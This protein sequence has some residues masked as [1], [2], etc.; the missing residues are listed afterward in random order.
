MDTEQLRSPHEPAEEPR[1]EANR[2]AGEQFDS[3]GAMSARTPV[4]LESEV[5]E[6]RSQLVSVPAGP[7]EPKRAPHAELVSS[8]LG[9]RVFN[10]I[11][12][13]FAGLIIVLVVMMIG[14][15]VVQARTSIVQFGPSFLTSTTWDS[16]KDVYGAAPSILGTV[17]TS[18]LALLLAAPVG[19]LL[20]V[21]LVEVAP[22]RLRFPI[23]FVIEL[24]AAVPSI[25]FGLWALF[26]LVPLVAQYIQP[27]LIGHF[28][29]TPFFN[30]APIGLGYLTA[31]LILAV[32]ILP[33][34]TSISRDVMQAVPNSQRDA[35]LAL[36]A[37]RW[38]MVW[39]VVVPYAR[40]GI[41]GAIGLALGRAIGET[42]AVQMVIGNALSFNIS[43]FN[44]GTTMPATIVNQ[45]AEATSLQKSSLIELALILMIVTI[46]LNAASRLL[47]SRS[48]VR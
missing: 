23:G 26:V 13:G 16:V 9:D 43:L 1:Q 12:A 39:R 11:T 6:R 24:L 44:A 15:L 45:F 34:I 33:T 32:M 48:G 10:A 14:V 5:V 7:R 35:M 22:R 18:L 20:A 31:S 30:G 41:I 46:A 29:S 8:N 19:V 21:F 2:R 36:G 47:V 42:M 40:S 3:G 25:V 17:Y 38:E 37:T 28:G 4:R 27:W